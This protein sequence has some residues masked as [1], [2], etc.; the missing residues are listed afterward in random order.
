MPLGGLKVV[1]ILTK[2][3]RMRFD[4]LAHR[5]RTATHL[6]R[7]ARIIDKVRDIFGL[8]MHAPTH[9]VVFCVNE[10]FQISA[11]TAPNPCGRCVRATAERPTRATIDRMGRPRCLLPQREDQRGEDQR[12]DHTV[13]STASLDRVFGSSCTR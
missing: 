2:D 10:E 8:S 9:G 7:R 12:A 6:A 11:L 1:L 4:S 13:S 5:S 3:D